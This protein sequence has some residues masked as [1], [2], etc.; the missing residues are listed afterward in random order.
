MFLYVIKTYYRNTHKTYTSNEM[1]TP[2]S[3]SLDKIY[4]SYILTERW[5]D[6]SLHT[7]EKSKYN[8]RKDC[9]D[10]TISHG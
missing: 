4:T 9:R 2:Q 1:S 6:N 5:V 10:S 3:E 8:K 7:Y